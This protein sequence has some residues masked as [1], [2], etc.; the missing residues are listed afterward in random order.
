MSTPA[1]PAR[2]APRAPWWRRGYR[3]IA[4]IAV[5]VLVYFGV[6]VYPLLRILTLAFPGWQP[7]T[8][9]LA[10]L[11]AG[12]AAGRL[13]CELLPGSATRAVSAVVMTWLGMS[14]IAFCLV[15]PW[16]LFALVLPLE[17][18]ASGLALLTGVAGVTATAFV[19]AQR[20]HLRKLEIPAPPP[21]KN[22]TLVQLTD[23]HVGSRRGGLLARAVRLANRAR[24][25]YVMITGD[26]VDFR[27][28]PAQE[29]AALADL[30]APAFFIIGNHERYVDCDAICARLEAL[31]I[32]VLRNRSLRTGAL[33]VVGI[34]DAEPKTQVGRVLETLTPDPDAYRILLYHRPDG[35]TDA[36]RWGAQLMLCG[37]T[38]NGQLVPFDRVVKRV[39]PLIQ[40]LYRV[41][42][43]HLYVSPG[44]GTWGPV[45][46]LGSRC[47]VTAIRL[48]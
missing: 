21:A 24:P 13:L 23:V 8:A 15:L 43:M 6:L 48:V 12:P 42:G 36:A 44:T 47:E 35:A 41:D 2:P 37:H 19:N 17:S 45:L 5:F 31:G 9:E 26:L 4:P 7:G 32:T 16:E 33:Q 10:L 30:R 22:L 46:R 14:F 11:M 1:T 38:H 3:R 18:R 28:V 29:L 27:H 39:F 40:G 34:D 25:D 20:L